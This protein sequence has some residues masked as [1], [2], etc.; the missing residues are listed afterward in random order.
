MTG[1][2]ADIGQNLRSLSES[3]WKKKLEV[4]ICYGSDSDV[5]DGKHANV[6]ALSHGWGI[7]YE[8]RKRS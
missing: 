3:P 1:A 5:Q 7:P 4:T 6:K 2:V 8:I